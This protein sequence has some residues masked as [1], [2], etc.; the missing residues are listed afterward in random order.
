MSQ[1]HPADQTIKTG[2]EEPGGGAH[3][4]Q[5][6]ADQ[7]T[8]SQPGGNIMPPTLLLSLPDYQTKRHLLRRLTYFDR[9][10][11]II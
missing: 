6:L 1:H 9:N 2:M 8:L 3:A 10:G 11:P 7:L 5:I 4:P